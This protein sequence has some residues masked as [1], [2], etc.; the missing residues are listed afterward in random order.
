MATPSVQTLTSSWW[1]PR[2]SRSTVC[3]LRNEGL[4]SIRQQYSGF[5]PVVLMVIMIYR[6][7]A[8][9]L[10]GG[11]RHYAIHTVASSRLAP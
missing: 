5:E 1:A 10:D 7:L 3:W 9:V 6:M 8:Q 4:R 11:G 2:S